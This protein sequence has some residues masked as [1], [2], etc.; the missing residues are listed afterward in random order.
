MVWCIMVFLASLQCTVRYRDTEIVVRRQIFVVGIRGTYRYQCCGAGAGAGAGGAATFCW[1]RGRRQSFFFD[2]ETGVKILIKCYK[3]PKFFIFKFEIYFKNHKLIA[4][5]FKEPFDDHLPVPVRYVFKKH[6]NLLKTMKI[7]EF[8]L[9]IWGKLSELEPEP[10]F[11]ISWSRSRTK[12]DRLR[13][14]DRFEH[15]YCKYR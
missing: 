8:F 5:Y 14:T 2:P 1:S 9:T 6:K 12:M 7:V 15:R 10:E 13:N 4:I 11:L 3:N